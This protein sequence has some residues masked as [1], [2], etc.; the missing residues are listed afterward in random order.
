MF[1]GFLKLDVEAQDNVFAGHRVCVLEHAQHTALGIGFDFLIT[2]MA[3]QLRLVEFFDP[4]LADGLSPAVLDRIQ[5]LGFFLVDSS[6]IADR[7]SE[8]LAQWIVPNELGLDI[9]AR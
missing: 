4:G 6:D 7:M 1:G 5:C 9:E 2:D 3:V 8:M